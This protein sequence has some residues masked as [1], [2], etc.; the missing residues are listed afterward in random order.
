LHQ[1]QRSLEGGTGRNPVVDHHAD[2]AGNRQRRPVASQ[3]LGPSLHLGELALRLDADVFVRDAVR[4]EDLI[5]HVGGSILGHG[6][7]G[8]LGI[9]RCAEL[10]C[11]QDVEVT[12]EPFGNNG[13]DRDAAPRH[14]ENQ[15]L[16]VRS[17][18]LSH[19]YRQLFSRIDPVAVHDSEDIQV[20]V[21]RATRNTLP[22]M[23]RLLL[24][25]N[26]SASGF[27][28]ALFRDVVRILE[29]DFQVDAEWPHGAQATRRR[30]AEAAGEGYHVV[31]AMGGDGVAHHVA[32]GLAYTAAS[33][34]IIPAGT[35][36][37]LARIF[38]LHGEPK[39]AAAAMA[40][41][42]ALP[43]RMAAL[44]AETA[45]GTMTE[46]ATFAV[47]AGFD[48]D[49][50]ALAEER[51]QSKIW[52]GGAHYAQSALSK[53]VLDW[54]NR[55][56][57]L[58]VTA[59]GERADGV[60][61]MVQVHYPYTFLGPIPLQITTGPVDGLAAICVANLE[62]HR[63]AEIFLRA[64]F[65]RPMAERLDAAVWHG[66]GELVV[67]AEPPTPFQADG[68]LLGVA[69]RLV[70]TDAPEALLA[71]RPRVQD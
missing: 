55:P 26:P 65:R 33:L 54:R 11:N 50:V 24:L 61:A 44:E 28:G 64:M 10:V 48:A 36:N 1:A 13:R 51:P 53:L 56:P 17:Q 71:L 69:D 18:R 57:N 38:R 59:N 15:R 58:S 8:V 46:L 12:A 47:G 19:C 2:S 14:P 68:E 21:C 52:L 27:T 7:D 29:R 45:S 63:S 43:T 35:T 32:N 62:V 16:V 25:A 67:D 5:V 9:A 49:V 31:A 6:A 70:V 66:F 23:R 37:V 3:Q 40:S 30:A 22:A 20:I 34:G 60:A 42:P 39:R 4:G 41:L